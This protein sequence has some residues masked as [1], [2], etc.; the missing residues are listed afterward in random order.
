VLMAV[1]ALN[2][3]SQRR[4]DANCIVGKGYPGSRRYL[5]SIATIGVPGPAGGGR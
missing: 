2:E 4:G 3:L 5:M 1:V